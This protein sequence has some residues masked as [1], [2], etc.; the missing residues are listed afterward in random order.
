MSIAAVGDAFAVAVC[1]AIGLD[2]KRITACSIDIQAG[3]LPKL[4][5]SLALDDKDMARIV[6]ALSA[7]RILSAPSTA[8][9]PEDISNLAHEV[10]ASIKKAPA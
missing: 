10:L 3:S 6:A 4:D 2:A 8:L 9:C 5:V 1:K 7:D